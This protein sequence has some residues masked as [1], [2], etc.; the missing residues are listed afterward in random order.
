MRAKK[1]SKRKWIIQ[2]MLLLLGVLTLTGLT[3]T[4]APEVTGILRR[5]DQFKNVIDS[6]GQMSVLVFIAFQ[7]IQ[8]VVSVIP[9]DVVQIAGGYIYGTFWGTVYSAAGILIG[10]LAAFY[11][12]RLL[13]SGAIRFFVS[14]KN[15]QRR[16][17]MM[18]APR[19]E[20]VLFLFF[21]IPGLPKDIL[22]YAAGLSP[23]RSARFFFLFTV[24]RLPGL[25]GSSVI[26]ANLQQENYS[27]V[28]I[29]FSICC[30][31]FGGGFICRKRILAFIKSIGASTPGR[32]EGK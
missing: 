1:G 31:L 11:G 28:I 30:L 10:T 13:G 12:A 18:D 8:V 20:T 15:M 23:I 5:P 32:E 19:S 6:Y 21:L 24:A 4:V 29:L 22:V 3:V 14:E 2:I 26:G 25:V 9:G 16:H 27:F 7:V 17:Q